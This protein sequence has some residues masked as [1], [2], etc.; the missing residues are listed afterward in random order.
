MKKEDWKT[1]KDKCSGCGEPA[2]VICK[3]EVANF[4]VSDED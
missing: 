2:G 1:G 3:C 4:R